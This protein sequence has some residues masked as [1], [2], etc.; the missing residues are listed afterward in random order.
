MELVDDRLW[1]KWR[2][3]VRRHC[4]VVEARTYVLWND[5]PPHLEPRG[6]GLRERRR[7][8]HAAAAV[9]LL[10]ERWG[11][12]LVADTAVRVVLEDVE[13]EFAGELDEP[14][15]PVGA[16]RAPAWVLERRDRV[17][18]GDGAALPEL[19]LDGFEIETLVVHRQR[20]HLGAV[21]AEE[22]EGPVVG[23][24]LDE[25]PAR[26]ARKLHR[27]P[28]HESLE[29][30]GREEHVRRIDAVPLGEQLAQ[31][32]VAATCAVGEDRLAVPG[33]CR[34]GAI[35]DQVRVETVGR[36]S[37]TGERDRRHDHEPTRGYG[38]GR[39]R[40][41]PVRVISEMQMVD[42]SE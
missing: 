25:H 24:P 5:E 20:Y 11:L 6:D 3:D 23:R 7:E 14:A 28:E 29:P 34:P 26:F 32:A 36:R 22:L 30:A 4:S 27:A 1:Q 13:T 40:P 38:A 37:T 19:G 2:G 18:E 12:A 31:R 8:R 41:V 10:Q 17:Q 15:S 35:R 21:P 16:E 39:P 9:E 42:P 33:E